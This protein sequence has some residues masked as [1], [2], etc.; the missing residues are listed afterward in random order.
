MRFYISQLVRV[1]EPTPSKGEVGDTENSGE[2]EVDK[3]KNSADE[4]EG[5]LSAE[6]SSGTLDKSDAESAYETG[7]A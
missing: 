1:A 7:S 3:L 5:E 4:S 6:T 2:S